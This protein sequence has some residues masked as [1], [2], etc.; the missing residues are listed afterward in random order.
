M[1]KVFNGK[2]TVH[3]RG[4]S[5][6]PE[7]HFFANTFFHKKTGEYELSFFKGF[8][9]PYESSVKHRVCAQGGEMCSGKATDE[10]ELLCRS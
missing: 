4:V 2:V 1:Y 6:K 9:P 3:I 10:L 7:P 5:Y 8:G